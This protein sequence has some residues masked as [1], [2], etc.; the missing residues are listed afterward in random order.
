MRLKIEYDARLPDDLMVLRSKEDNAYIPKV[1]Q[2]LAEPMGLD[3]IISQQDTSF[4]PIQTE[5]VYFFFT[6]KKG[7]FL[8]TEQ[9]I[10]KT[11]ERL[12]ELEERLPD[13]F[14]RI[15]RF[16]IINLHFLNRFEFT[17]GGKFVLHMSNGEK[18]FTTKTYTKAIKQ[19]L[20]KKGGM[21]DGKK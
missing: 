12:Y 11:D 3:M 8:K 16:E 1:N 7:V 4:Y 13:H 14:V 9:G 2:I 5:K 17:F 10:F 21:V 19:L 6:E 15:S 18:L 20:F